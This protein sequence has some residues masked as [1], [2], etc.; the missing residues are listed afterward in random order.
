MADLLNLKDKSVLKNQRILDL[1]MGP[2]RWS[3]LFIQAGFSV[4]TGLD[5]QPEMVA[6]AKKRIRNSNFR[7]VLGDMK[8][9][10]F[11]SEFFEKVF[12][13]RSIKYVQDLNLVLSEIN[14]VLV[15]G[16]TLVVEFP[17]NSLL[18]QSISWL[19]PVVPLRIKSVRWYLENSSFYTKEDVVSRL[20]RN[21]LTVVRVYP[22]FILPASPLPTLGGAF[23]WFWIVLDYIG[24]RT[25]SPKWFARSWVVSAVKVNSLKI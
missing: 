15:P 8:K 12:S 4:V 10:P 22:L 16:G 23:T 3:K 11:K 19:L 1:G 13:F 5:I 24:S 9:L 21:G 6:Q 2:G 18:I 17:N 7:A 25:L 20:N 14:R